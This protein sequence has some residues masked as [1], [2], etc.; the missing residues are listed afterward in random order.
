MML[1]SILLAS[2]GTFSKGFIILFREGFEALLILFILLG[3]L[4]KSGRSE[5]A[6][7]LYWG[8]LMA[9]G[10]S[11][12]I[13]LLLGALKISMEGTA[14]KVFE[15]LAMYITALLLGGMIL[16]MIRFQ[17]N[18]AELK[19][20]A[21]SLADQNNCWGLGL[22]M[23][24]SVLREGLETVLLFMGPVEEGGNWWAGLGGGLLGLAF[25]AA[26]SFALFNGLI[27]LNFSLFFN[28]TTGILLF[29]AAGMVAYG[30]HELI[31][32]G[33]LPAIQEKVWNINPADLPDGSKHPFHD[34]GSV[35]GL[36]KALFGYNG[37]PDLLE[38]LLWLGYL[39]GGGYLWYRLKPKKQS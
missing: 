12:L 9:V 2:A 29:M 25:A 15:G 39:M 27:R 21:A 11:L 19:S 4:K 10:A 14:E 7:A 8:A 31:E 33:W 6:P 26:L 23:F 36:L 30:T 5:Q 28:V 18:T 24:F 34:K 22:L 17:G 3:F 16:W 13:G 35:G 37:D 32:A 1:Q 38:L 20:Q